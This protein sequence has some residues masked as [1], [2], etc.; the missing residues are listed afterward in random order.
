MTNKSKNVLPSAY[1]NLG[2]HEH[3]CKI[4]AHPQREEIEDAFI[5]WRS[6]AK[7]ATEY[8]FHRASVYRHARAYD[9]FSK[10]DRNLRGA[11]SHII[12]KASDVPVNA[13]AIVAAVSAY[14]RI[15]S[16]GRAIDRQQTINLNDLFDRMSEEELEAYAEDGILPSWFKLAVGETPNNGPE[17]K[18]D[19]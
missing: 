10:R 19:E 18:E 13:S 16:Q 7:I 4:C 15:N 6:P 3:G 8:K 2:R 1:P 5:S 12:E 11:L 9:L 14:A 17:G